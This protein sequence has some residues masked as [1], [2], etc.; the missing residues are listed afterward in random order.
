VGVL[1]F[2]QI[3]FLPFH[4]LRP[5]LAER[6]RTTLY[7]LRHPQTKLLADFAQPG[8]AATILDYIV[9]KRR[10]RHVFVTAGFQHQRSHRHQM[11]EIWHRRLLPRL[12]GMLLSGIAEGALQTGSKMRRLQRNLLS[13]FH[14]KCGSGALHRLDGAE[15]RLHTTDQTVKSALLTVYLVSCGPDTSCPIS[16]TGMSLS[17]FFAPPHAQISLHQRPQ[18]AIQHTI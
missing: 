1:Y 12:S 13:S 18:I 4:P 10:D 2:A 14:K 6:I 3:V 11:R 16:Q 7:H 5:R 17:F 8:H 9:Q 15:P